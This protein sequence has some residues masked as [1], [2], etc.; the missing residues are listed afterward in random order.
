MLDDDLD[1]FRSLYPNQKPA[2][3][4]VR[5]TRRAHKIARQFSPLDPA[6]V[7]KLARE[8]LAYSSRYM[9][10]ARQALRAHW[11]WDEPHPSPSSKASQEMEQ[12]RLRLEKEHA[13]HVRRENEHEQQQARLERDRLKRWREERAP[14][15]LRPPHLRAPRPGF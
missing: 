12:E 9:G 10:P 2:N 11:Q 1:L 14:D 3:T 15:H 6:L 13:N 4:S 7:A 5:L 8:P